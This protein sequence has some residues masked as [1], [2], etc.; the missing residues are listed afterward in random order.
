MAT[1]SDLGNSRK[2]SPFKLNIKAALN[3]LSLSPSSKLLAVGGREAF[4]IVKIVREN[5]LAGNVV[6]TLKEHKNLWSGRRMA[7]NCND[8]SWNLHDEDVLATGSTNGAVVIYRKMQ[9][10]HVFKEHRQRVHR[11]NWHSRDGNVLMSASQDGTVK[12]WDVRSKVCAGTFNNGRRVCVYDIRC[13][14]EVQSTHLF[15]AAL[16]NGSFQVWDRRNARS[17]VRKIAAHNRLVLSLDWHPQLRGVIASGG[18]DGTVKAWNVQTGKVLHTIQTLASVARVK[19]RQGSQQQ[20]ASSSSVVDQTV[21][22][23]DVEYP[24]VPIA[25]L[26]GHR[27]VV[28][29]L[30]WLSDSETASKSS[31][32]NTLLT[33]SKDKHV[34][35][36]SLA[37]ASQPLRHVCTSG[38]AVSP[39]GHITVSCDKLPETRKYDQNLRPLARTSA[40]GHDSGR[41]AKISTIAFAQKNAGNVG[42]GLDVKLLTTLAERYTVVP[43]KRTTLAAKRRICDEAEEGD[44]PNDSGV[45]DSESHGEFNIH[46]DSR[47]GAAHRRGRGKDDAEFDNGRYDDDGE[48]MMLPPGARKRLARRRKMSD[49]FNLEGMRGDS[50][51][52]EPGR[53]DNDNDEEEDSQLLRLASAMEEDDDGLG[54]LLDQLDIANPDG[55]VDMKDESDGDLYASHSQ[56]DGLEGPR[57]I[58]A[59]DA[60]IML[61]RG[62]KIEEGKGPVINTDGDSLLSPDALKIRLEASQ[63]ERNFEATHGDVASSST[64]SGDPEQKEGGNAVVGSG[65][66]ESPR[67]GTSVG[68]TVASS[69]LASILRE[70]LIFH[71]DRGDVQTCAVISLIVGEPASTAVGTKQVQQWYF[72]YVELLGRLRSPICAAKFISSAEGAVA[73]L[74]QMSTTIHTQCTEC[75]RPVPVTSGAKCERCKKV[76]RCSVCRLPMMGLVSWCSECG[77]GTHFKCGLAWFKEND[78]CPAGCG[79][80]CRVKK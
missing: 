72:A 4:H 73:Q 1:S 77:H 40:R 23:W 71:G 54:L 41:S 10:L 36:S 31:L 25:V 15:A 76:A 69:A 61:G 79:Y 59:A 12:T 63:N 24:A 70:L 28:S 56:K 20:I 9:R 13:A 60:L 66:M 74:N 75:A 78:V 80:R 48:G 65:G 58:V 30:A 6:Y 17:C 7:L 42:F 18:C 35:V 11:I 38:M 2:R 67:A 26:G 44:P 33:C 39:V 52:M 5:E 37:I 49:G 43:A 62:E 53:D 14:P 8:V 29:G 68:A 21:K 50:F 57:G 32:A 55:A 51:S 46:L 22:I 27:D 3:A 64:G 16:D 34:S 47:D 19:W 45:E